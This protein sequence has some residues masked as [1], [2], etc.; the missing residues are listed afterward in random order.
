MEFEREFIKVDSALRA[1][2]LSDTIRH[3]GAC[4]H[5]QIASL[6]SLLPGTITESCIGR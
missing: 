6:E 4:S 2:A 3:A 5:M 1:V